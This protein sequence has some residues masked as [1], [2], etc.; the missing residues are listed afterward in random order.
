MFLF[1]K[2]FF[3]GD[4]AIFLYYLDYFNF[5]TILVTGA[6]SYVG[7]R[8]YDDLKKKHEVIGTYHKNKLFPALQSLDITNKNEVER[9]ILDKKPDWIIHVAANASG[10]WCKAHPDEAI[11]INETGT[12]NIVEAANKVNSKVVLISSFAI[13]DTESIYSKTKIASENFVKETKAGYIILRPSL[14]VGFGPNTIN[15]RPFNRL[16]KNILENTPAVYDTS[17]RFQPTWLKHISEVIE[18]IIA[19]KMINE[20]IPVSVPELKNRYDIANDILSKFDIKAIPEDKH[21]TTPIFSE[22]L[23]KLKELK[24]PFYSYDE[25]IKGI[26]QETK[27]YLKNR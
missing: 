6:S 16:L 7:A 11:A 24:L 9:F 21:D 20:T 10:S 8:I 3:R 22:R 27:D 26:V 19:K 4:L 18:E 25:M 15:D 12:K 23:D 1:L 5:M 13:I 2:H 17:W 14:I